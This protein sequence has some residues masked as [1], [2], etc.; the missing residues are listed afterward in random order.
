M[1]ADDEDLIEVA[2]QCHL[3]EI[4]G[5]D[6]ADD[7]AGSALR[8]HFNGR[9]T[10]SAAAFAGK[11][12]LSD[13]N[14]PIARSQPSPSERRIFAAFAACLN[15]HEVRVLNVLVK[16]GKSR[17]VAVRSLAPPPLLVSGARI[18]HAPR[19]PPPTYVGRKTFV[20]DPLPLAQARARTLSRR[21][22]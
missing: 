14:D 17:S 2:A 20:P 8:P 1:S 11:S 16:R 22:H 7:G 5:S 15:A 4:G 13:D 6:F 9:C 21:V 18:T 10:S 12:R 19:V 3:A